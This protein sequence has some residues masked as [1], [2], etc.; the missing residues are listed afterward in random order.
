MYITVQLYGVF[1]EVEFNDDKFK[2]N[3]RVLFWVFF[4]FSNLKIQKKILRECYAVLTFFSLLIQ[5]AF[6][7]DFFKPK[8]LNFWFSKISA[9]ET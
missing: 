2:V 8:K 5:K 4:S 6:D 7:D 1:F 3:D 9:S